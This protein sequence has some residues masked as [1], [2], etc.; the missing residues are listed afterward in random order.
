MFPDA[1]AEDVADTALTV[2]GRME[3]DTT[4]FFALDLGWPLQAT[5]H[6]VQAVEI[7][8][9]GEL[10]TRSTYYLDMDFSVEM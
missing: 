9:D 6:S 7:L 3:A 2:Q 5:G 10:V 8:W 1:P 4:L